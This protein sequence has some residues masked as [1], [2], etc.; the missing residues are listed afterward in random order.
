MLKALSGSLVSKRAPWYK[1]NLAFAIGCFTCAEP[2]FF[3]AFSIPQT[4]DG[5]RQGYF[6]ITIEPV[7][8]RDA[9]LMKEIR[10]RA[11]RDAPSAFSSTY[12]KESELSD[13][14]WVERTAQSSSTNASGSRSQARR[15]RTRT[16]LH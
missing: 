15:H 7:R 13:A 3:C 11:L 5:A 16:I 10:L 4:I 6:V 2:R 8:Q 9:M 12:E 1:R 14:D